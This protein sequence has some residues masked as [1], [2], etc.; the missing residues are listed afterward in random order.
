M[1]GMCAIAST[2]FFFGIIAENRKRNA[3]GRDYRY[4]EGEVQLK[5]TATII[6]IFDSIHKVGL[7]HL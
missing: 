1:L 7:G 2:M 3:G 4:Q 6:Q 5:N